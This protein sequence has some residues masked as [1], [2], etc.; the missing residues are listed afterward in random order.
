MFIYLG[1]INLNLIISVENI[2]H[3]KKN[4]KWLS[5]NRSGNTIQLINLYVDFPYIYK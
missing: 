1:L 5:V 3:I 2:P 4:S